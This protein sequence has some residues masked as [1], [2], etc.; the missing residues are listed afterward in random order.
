MYRTH[1]LRLQ[2][3][4]QEV[5]LLVGVKVRDILR[6]I[7]AIKSIEEDKSSTMSPRGCEMRMRLWVIRFLRAKIYNE[8]HDHF[9]KPPFATTYW[10]P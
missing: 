10:P 3:L 9:V 6:M 2:V 1:L 5:G 7:R 8:T 4:L